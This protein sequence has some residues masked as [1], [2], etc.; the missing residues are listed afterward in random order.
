MPSI[1]QEIASEAVPEQVWAA[2][3][4]VSAV[5]RRLVPSHVVDTRVDGDTGILPFPSGGVIRELI[6]AVDDEARRLAYAVVASRMPLVHH[7]ASFQVFADGEGRS[8]LVWI[9]DFLPHE[10]AIE[11]RTHIERGAAVMKETLE[12]AVGAVSLLGPRFLRRQCSR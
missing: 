10:L 11:I 9:A 3:R 12:A 5:H 1:R 7:L 8:R 6:G 2:V 4:D